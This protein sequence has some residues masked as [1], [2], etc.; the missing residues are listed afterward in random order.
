VSDMAVRGNCILAV[1]AHLLL[2]CRMRVMRN[3]SGLW[4]LYWV[5]NSGQAWELY[6]KGASRRTYIQNAWYRGHIKRCPALD[7]PHHG[8][9]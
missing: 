4:H 2:G 5:D 6:A 3:R 8:A 1:V 9:L 7:E